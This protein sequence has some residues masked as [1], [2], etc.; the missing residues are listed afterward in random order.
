MRGEGVCRSLRQKAL[1]RMNPQA[2]HV[3]SGIVGQ[4]GLAIVDAIPGGERD[5][6]AKPRNGRIKADEEV[7]AKSL[8]GDYRP[9]HLFTLRQSLAAYRSYQK[10]IDDGTVRFATAYTIFSPPTRLRKPRTRPGLH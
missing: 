7:I 3:I 10:L 2:H 4:T 5:P 6:R 8:A 9:E 1:D